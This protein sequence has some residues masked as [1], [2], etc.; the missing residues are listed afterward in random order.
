MLF[1]LKPLEGRYESS[2]HIPKILTWPEQHVD[3][4]GTN[5]QNRP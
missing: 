4:A 3:E 2:V 1:S 5:T